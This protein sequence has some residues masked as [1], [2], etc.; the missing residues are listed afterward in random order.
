MTSIVMDVL[1]CIYFMFRL[2]YYMTKCYYNYNIINQLHFH[3]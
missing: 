2:R 3:E 1:I